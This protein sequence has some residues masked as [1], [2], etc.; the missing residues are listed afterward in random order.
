MISLRSSL[1]L[2]NGMIF[3]P[4]PE[5]VQNRIFP[6][7]AFCVEPYL[8]KVRCPRRHP[9][10][11]RPHPAPDSRHR[12]ERF[13]YSVG[14][15]DLAVFPAFFGVLFLI[16]ATQAIGME[17]PDQPSPAQSPAPLRHPHCA[18]GPRARISLA[19]PAH[20]APSLCPPPPAAL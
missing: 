8:N 19:H 2:L 15:V 11:P 12:R 10:S 3:P 18:G 17:L 1:P 7:I 16:G 13:P 4:A 9:P 6:F 20:P 5:V 14:A